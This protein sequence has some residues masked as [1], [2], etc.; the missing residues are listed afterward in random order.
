MAGGARL[1]GSVMRGAGSTFSSCDLKLQLS[2]MYR[3]YD[4]DKDELS[5]DH[6]VQTRRFAFGVFVFVLI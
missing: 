3:A 1:P 5:I 6:S 2:I 4:G